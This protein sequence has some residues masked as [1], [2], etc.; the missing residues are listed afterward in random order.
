MDGLVETEMALK[1]ENLLWI[2]V[3]FLLSSNLMLGFQLWNKNNEISSLELRGEN[4][5]ILQLGQLSAHDKSSYTS[6]FGWQIFDSEGELKMLA[7]I[8]ENSSVNLRCLGPSGSC[9]NLCVSHVGAELK[10]NAPD[11][12]NRCIIEAISEDS[13]PHISV[14][15]KVT[16]QWKHLKFE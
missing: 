3:L 8:S 15:N 13:E 14:M 2:L 16:N 5:E 10:L 11:L 1:K 9:F 6:R 7:Y 4:G 12:L